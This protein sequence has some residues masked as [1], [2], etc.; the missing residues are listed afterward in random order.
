M[1]M[2]KL[3]KDFGGRSLLNNRAEI[4]EK[5]FNRSKVNNRYVFPREELDDNVSRSS[6]I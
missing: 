2:L 4:I 6:S 3:G 1:D 5:R